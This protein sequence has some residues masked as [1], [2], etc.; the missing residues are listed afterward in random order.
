MARPKNA[1]EFL[2]GMDRIASGYKRGFDENAA[3]CECLECGESYTSSYSALGEGYCPACAIDA[4]YGS[5][6]DALEDLSE[7][8]KK[9]ERRE[10]AERASLVTRQRAGQ[11]Q[12]WRANQKP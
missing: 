12:K 1:Q 11:P 5:T 10:T 7:M 8:Q 9:R 6:K 2:M 4:F 3:R